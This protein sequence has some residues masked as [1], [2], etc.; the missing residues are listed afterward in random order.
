MEPGLWP[1]NTPPVIDMVLFPLLPNRLLNDK[2]KRIMKMPFENIEQGIILFE[3]FQ[4]ASWII[5]GA[6]PAYLDMTDGKNNSRKLHFGKCASSYQNHPPRE[7]FNV[8]HVKENEHVRH[9][10]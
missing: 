10:T 3:D 9:M 2:Q 8:A 4:I 5:S 7:I 1:I 6:L